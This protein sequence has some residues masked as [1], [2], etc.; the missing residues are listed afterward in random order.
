MQG[1]KYLFAYSNIIFSRAK[2]EKMNRFIVFG[3]IFSV[4][5]L[6]MIPNISAT[7]YHSIK[8]NNKRYLDEFNK[9]LLLIS[10]SEELDS[11]VIRNLISRFKDTFELNGIKSLIGIN[12]YE[13][14]GK[15]ILLSVIL[16]ILYTIGI[17]FS[18]SFIE[19][20]YLDHG[21]FYVG[22]FLLT[23][24]ESILDPEVFP[25]I[26][27][28]F[29]L[30]FIGPILSVFLFLIFAN[31]Y[32]PFFM[33]LMWPISLPV[34]ILFNSGAI[35][36]ELMQNLIGT[37][38]IIGYFLFNY[39][40]SITSL[41]INAINLVILIILTIILKILERN[42]GPMLTTKGILTRFQTNSI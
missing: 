32:F 6:L 11:D 42:V 12:S 27:L 2:G 13:K 37:I 19:Q 5:L 17:I 29:L 20:I 3:S 15:Q 1:E 25:P 35:S 22:E 24:M 8:E 36:E 21:E 39:I 33:S 31:N 18:Y 40:L 9:N 14:D 23:L 38:C 41:I 7:E 28:P 30:F 34:F 10:T 16:L 4:F 26:L